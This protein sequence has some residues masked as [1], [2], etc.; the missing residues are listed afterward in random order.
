MEE[1]RVYRH[2]SGDVEAVK[3]GWSWPGAILVG[4]WALY[5][6]LWIIGSA[7]LIVSVLLHA[8]FSVMSNLP[9][10]FDL[11][12][13]VAFG[14]YG[15]A[16]RDTNLVDRGFALVDTVLAKTP[17]GAI[18]EHLRNQTQVAAHGAAPSSRGPTSLERIEP[19]L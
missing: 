5:K 16:W 7:V 8:M 18:A 11:V 3:V 1:F 14:I 19:T 13:A 15:N 6:K 17:D 12:C 9:L 10:L 2:P 4:F